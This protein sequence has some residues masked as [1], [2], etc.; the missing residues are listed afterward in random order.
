MFLNAIIN[1]R[2]NRPK[3]CIKFFSENQNKFVNVPEAHYH[4]PQSAIF[5]NEAPDVIEKF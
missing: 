4:P 5:I 3:N 2:R 1:S